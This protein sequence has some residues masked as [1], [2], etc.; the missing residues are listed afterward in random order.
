MSQVSAYNSLEEALPEYF[1]IKDYYGQLVKLNGGHLEKDMIK[2]LGT[3]A[4]EIIEDNKYREEG[5]LKLIEKMGFIAFQVINTS[6]DNC[7]EGGKA[8]SVRDLDTEKVFIDYIVSYC[9]H[10]KEIAVFY[11]ADDNVKRYLNAAIE[12]GERFVINIEKIL[13]KFDEEKARKSH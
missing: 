6:I 8:T 7:G 11:G 12:K 9:I 3:D 2:D 10:A 5:L 1:E 4:I 13:V